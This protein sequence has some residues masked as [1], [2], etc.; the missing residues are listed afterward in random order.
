MIC[1]YLSLGKRVLVTSKG[2]PALS[3]IRTRLPKGIQDLCVDVSLSESSGMRQLQRTV[4]RLA[5]RVACVNTHIEAEKCQLLDVSWSISDFWSTQCE[6][7]NLYQ[8][9]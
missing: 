3:V 2:A 4:E 1:A 7:R 6:L 9:P 5:N 8:V